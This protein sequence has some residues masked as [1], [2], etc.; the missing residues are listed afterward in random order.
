MNIAQQA[1]I[2]NAEITGNADDFGVSITLTAVTG[3]IAALTG[4]STKHHLGLNDLQQA[5]KAKT[6]SVNVHPINISAANALFPLRSAAGEVD[7]KDC[8]VDTADS[9]GEIKHYIASS[10][11]P[12]EKLGGIIIILEDY[13]A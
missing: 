11:L 4:W 9:T 1:I 2:D 7:L 6:A 12:D 13:T 8:L 10:W 3:E 5:V